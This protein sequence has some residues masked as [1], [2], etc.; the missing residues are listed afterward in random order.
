MFY[1]TIVCWFF[2]QQRG[3]KY[4][5]VTN[6]SGITEIIGKMRSQLVNLIAGMMFVAPMV[7][8]MESRSPAM[9]IRCHSRQVLIH[10]NFL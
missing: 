7:Q 10:V 5:H 4:H 3:E 2:P 6:G 9:N 8:W 1:K